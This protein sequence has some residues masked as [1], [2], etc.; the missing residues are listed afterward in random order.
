MPY[1]SNVTLPAPVRHH[2]PL[3]AQDLYREAFNGAW[4]TYAADVRREEI[5]HRT[6]WAAVKRQFHKDCDGQWRLNAH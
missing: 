6:A 3:R 4:S 5:A 1:A 2:L